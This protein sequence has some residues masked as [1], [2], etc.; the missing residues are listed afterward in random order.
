M[1]E[2]R[3]HIPWYSTTASI[4]L[5][6]YGAIPNITGYFGAATPN[7]HGTKCSGVF[8]SITVDNDSQFSWQSGT[9]NT[10]CY[11]YSI[12]ASKVSST[13]TSKQNGVLPDYITMYYV[14]KY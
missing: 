1:P 12:N 4:G 5:K 9:T 14:I 2:C 11:G 7:Y 6:G 13:Y 8:Q 10:S 3:D